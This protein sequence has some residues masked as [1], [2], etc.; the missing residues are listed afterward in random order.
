MRPTNFGARKKC[1]SSLNSRLCE[2]F[3]VIHTSITLIT[4]GVVDGNAHIWTLQ[5]I[6]INES[7]AAYP[8]GIVHLVGESIATRFNNYALII[9]NNNGLEQLKW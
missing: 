9:S 8:C 5:W 1:T 3:Y 7:L 4:A 6:M 2:L